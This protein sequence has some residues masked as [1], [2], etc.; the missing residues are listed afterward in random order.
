M[1]DTHKE[2]IGEGNG[3]YD[4]N[5]IPRPPFLPRNLEKQQHH[6]EYGKHT[7][8]P[9]NKVRNPRMVTQKCRYLRNISPMEHE[10]YKQKRKE[11]N[12]ICVE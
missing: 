3:R 2:Y 11:E 1:R 9:W 6:N 12:V 7:H 8:K 4:K 5:L 10:E